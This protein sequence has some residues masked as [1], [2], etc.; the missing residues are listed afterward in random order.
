VPI[1]AAA[2]AVAAAA[3]QRQKTAAVGKHYNT[4]CYYYNRNFIHTHLPRC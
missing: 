2:A 1:A 3:A 4:L